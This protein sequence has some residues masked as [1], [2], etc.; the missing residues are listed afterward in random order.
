MH[1][2]CRKGKNSCFA[3]KTLIYG[4]FVAK[5]VKKTQ[6]T[7]FEDNILRTFANEDKPQ[8]VEAWRSV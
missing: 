1:F 5:V 8:V 4:I 7:R 6:H 3:P 2:C